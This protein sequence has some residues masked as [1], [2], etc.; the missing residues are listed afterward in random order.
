MK[1]GKRI[2]LIYCLLLVG[3]A[4]PLSVSAQQSND[5]LASYYFSN[6]S[7]AEAIEIYESLYKRT[8]NQYYYQMLL[9]CY[10][11]QPDLKEAERLVERRQKKVPG[12]LTLY[13][14]LGQVYAAKND[15]KR[16]EKA[17]RE[18]I[19]RLGFDSRQLSSL[20]MSFEGISRPDLAIEAYLHMRSKTGANLSYVM[21]LATLYQRTGDYEK[22]MQEY[23]D[24]LD[25]APGNI[26][27]VQISLQRALT[28]TSNPRLAE[29]LRSALVSRIQSQPNNRQYLEMMIWFSLQQ[30]DF[31]FALTQAKA[32]DARFPD[33]GSDQLLRVADIAHT[34][35]DYATASQGYEA[36]AKKGSDDPNYYR[37][38]VGL[39]QN[40]FDRL[41]NGNP[42][43][44][45]SIASLERAYE[46]A[47]AELGK[48]PLTVPLMRNYAAL[49]AYHA[50]RVQAAVDI[51]YD[52]I[53]MPKVDKEALFEV[54]LE[55]G[56]L[57]L[58]AGEVW[59]ASLLYMQV[60]K[61]NKDNRLGA[62]AKF[63]N[64][65]LSYYNGDFQ[66]AKSQL[67]VLRASTSKLIANDAMQLS[68]LISDNIDEDSS[69]SMLALYAQADL[70]LYRN[71]LDSAWVAFDDIAHRALS[72]PLFDEVLFQK[73]S[74]RIKQ[75][76]YAEA[77]SLLQKLVDFYPDD[78]LAD[79]GWMTL[80]RLNEERLNN[81]ERARSCYEKILI[82]YPVSLYVDE[83]RKRY[84]TLK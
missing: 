83:A 79:D 38:R 55:L 70:L 65:K 30:K 80:G 54:K 3:L 1:M 37:A 58:F 16:A 40:E 39:L 17:Y 36:V 45:N 41:Q 63:R 64:A 24:L 9:R 52:V 22:M 13:V 25:G 62:M 21:E 56:D 59:D 15:A 28:E 35:A 2:L 84:N 53:E 20:V 18:A 51:L 42:V 7:Y 60:E 69:Y 32:V 76:R 73:A 82:D 33:L 46:A 81:K 50:H 49:E 74:I 23:F 75:G 72:H 67:D 26:G 77:D 34:N 43:A 14:D 29:G 19:D 78:I 5:Q 8:S 44:A 31:D 12:E 10:M 57:L 6:G 66:W 48:T 4:G 61:A 27:S 68:L 71:L 11:A 47:F